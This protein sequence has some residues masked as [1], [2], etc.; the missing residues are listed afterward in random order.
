[1]GATLVLG[2]AVAREEDCV[3]PPP[4]LPP[5]P[6]QKIDPKYEQVLARP[7]VRRRFRADSDHFSRTYENIEGDARLLQELDPVIYLV[8]ND[9]VRNLVDLDSVNSE[10]RRQIATVFENPNFQYALPIGAFTEL[11]WWFGGNVPSEQGSIALPQIRDGDRKEALKRLAHA[12][13][14]LPEETDE[15]HLAR[16]IAAT[17]ASFNN[18]TS[19]LLTFLDRSNFLGVFSDFDEATLT[20]LREILAKQE[21]RDRDKMRDMKDLH[22]AE[23]LAVVCKRAELRSRESA[24]TASAE[25]RIPSFVLLTQ[26][27]IVQHLPDSLL[28][29]AAHADSRTLSR[30]LGKP[31]EPE[32]NRH[33]LLF[34][35]AYPVL[36]PQRAHYVEELRRARG[37][38]DESLG[39]VDH[40]AA[41]YRRLAKIFQEPQVGFYHLPRDRQAQNVQQ[42]IEVL[43]EL[44]KYP[45]ESLFNL[46]EKERLLSQAAEAHHEGTAAVDRATEIEVVSAGTAEQDVFFETESLFRK[47]IRI[48]DIFERNSPTVYELQYAVD[49]SESFSRVTIASH[50]PEEIVMRGEVYLDEAVNPAPLAYSFRWQTIASERHFF[51]ALQTIFALKSDVGKKSLPAH[52]VLEPVNGSESDPAE[53]LVFFTNAG[54]FHTALADTFIPLARGARITDR[55][56]TAIGTMIDVAADKIELQAIRVH[57]PFGD[58]QLDLVNDDTGVREVF[59]I[60]HV[61]LAGQIVKLC[62]STSL[63]GVLP[64]RLTETLQPVT[65]QF[66]EYL[67][68]ERS[69]TA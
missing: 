64:R 10:E 18:I 31:S 1:M 26:T 38:T 6:I 69:V 29:V 12:V 40:I 15:G 4:T 67:P 63:L 36:A 41:T 47:L 28:N 42:L 68:A 60:S 65:T 62:Q 21:R 19:A 20:A 25:E 3:P 14:L 50:H 46:I 24:E 35:P 58:F 30:L 45:I 16:E 11:M 57:T 23:N 59:V 51:A 13:G 56:K 54:P 32:S 52:L 66:P 55:V 33:P 49:A 7:S 61:N 43:D 2:P 37:L 9:V 17:V 44:G 53:S 34:P 27:L 39:W 8:D 5:S 22:D 48:N